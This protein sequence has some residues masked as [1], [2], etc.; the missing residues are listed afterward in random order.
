MDREWVEEATGNNNLTPGKHVI[1]PWPVKGGSVEQWKAVVVEDSSV[2]KQNKQ[3]RVIARRKR[4][5]RY[6]IT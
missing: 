1:I 6:F 4:K 2:H 5:V 3:R